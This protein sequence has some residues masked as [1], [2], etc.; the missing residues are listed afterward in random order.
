MGIPQIILIV[1]LCLG[2]EGHRQQYVS[3][4]DNKKDFVSK[5]LAILT[6]VG[7]LWWGGFWGG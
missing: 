3:G 4:L 7:L 6:L 2:F 5:I 1:L